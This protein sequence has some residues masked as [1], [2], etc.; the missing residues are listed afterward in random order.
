MNAKT[1][2]SKLNKEIKRHNEAINLLA[3]EAMNNI[4]KPLCDKHRINFWSGNGDYWFEITP[5][6]ESDSY[7][8]REGRVG[9]VQDAKDAGLDYL[10]DIFK[11]L[12]EEIENRI[13]FGFYLGCYSGMK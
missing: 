13:P 5:D 3:Y 8:V 1:L 6:P 11:I 10:L 7:V 4:I 9:T 2:Q 12:D